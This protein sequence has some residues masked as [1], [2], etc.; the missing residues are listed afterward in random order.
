[1]LSVGHDEY[2]SKPMRDRLEAFIA[3][4][5]NVAFFSGNVACWQVRHEDDALVCFKE[6]YR[7]DPLYRP[8]GPNPLLSTLSSHYLLDRP[9]NMLTG[10]GVLGG[11]FHK[12]HGQY[13]D[14]SGA[15]TVH[16]CAVA[17]AASLSSRSVKQPRNMRPPRFQA[18]S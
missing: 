14:G 17:F 3:R 9:E 15:F 6:Y 10:V 8:D 5:G 1:V 13:M 16:P 18:A 12:S 4:G 2:W 11:G 7:D